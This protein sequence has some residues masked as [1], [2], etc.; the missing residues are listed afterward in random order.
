MHVNHTSAVQLV[1]KEA[2]FPLAGSFVA[3][4]FPSPAD[5]YIEK[6]LDLNEYLIRNQAATFFVRASGDSMTGAG[7]HHGDILIVDRSIDP[8]PGQVVIAVVNGEMLVKR[9]RRVAGVPALFAERGDG[10]P[11]RITGAEEF[12]VWG[13]ATYALHPL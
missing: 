2:G 13:V 1:E 4:G 7:I 3:A 12:S 8:E 10:P 5:D 6:K 11:V 9:L